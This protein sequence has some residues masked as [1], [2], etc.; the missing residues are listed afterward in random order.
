M[1][2]FNLGDKVRLKS[3]VAKQYNIPSYM[4]LTITNILDCGCVVY[5]CDETDYLMWTEDDF[6]DIKYITSSNG[7]I[8]G[9]S[10]INDVAVTVRGNR[11]KK[12]EII[13]QL[14][15]AK[16]LNMVYKSLIGEENNIMKVKNTN[17]F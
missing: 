7:Q 17:I 6:E 1:T 13:N 2:K 14:E 15:F 12:F 8:I 10:P 9:T 3:D 11:S 4:T 16:S 5:R